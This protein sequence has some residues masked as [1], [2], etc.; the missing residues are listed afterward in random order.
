MP[1]ISSFVLV[2]GAGSGPWVFDTWTDSFDG[3]ELE[4]VDLQVGLRIESVSMSAYA[5]RVAKVVA[6]RQDPVYVCG[7]SMGGLVALMAA[8]QTPPRA[9][10]V[11]EPSPPAEVQ[12]TH[13]EVRLRSGTFDPD[14]VYGR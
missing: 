9:L 7:W 1:N 14:E 8:T 3:T 12:G 2:H 10:A 4:A 13:P 11:I 5:E 6:R